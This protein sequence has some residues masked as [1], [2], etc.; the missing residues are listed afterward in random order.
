MERRRRDKINMWILQLGNLIPDCLPS[1]NGKQPDSKGGIL[2]KACEYITELQSENQ[3]MEE[4]LRD[5]NET[6]NHLALLKQQF[7][8]LKQENQL[9][10]SH[11][12]QQPTYVDHSLISD[13]TD[14]NAVVLLDDSSIVMEANDNNASTFIGKYNFLNSNEDGL[15]VQNHCLQGGVNNDGK[16]TLNS[17]EIYQTDKTIF[18]DESKE[19]SSNENKVEEPFKKTSCNANL[20]TIILKNV[21]TQKRQGSVLNQHPTK[22]PNKIKE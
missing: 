1:N 17:A 11:L 18:S 16:E 3:E 21:S 2:S 4:N 20:K 22:K 10:R 6:K 14:S 19:T 12:Q 9:L 13:G 8:Q 5:F 15:Y 7:E